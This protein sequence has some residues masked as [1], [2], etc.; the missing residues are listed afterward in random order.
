[1]QNIDWN[2]LTF[3]YTDVRCHIRS[4]WRDGK[5]ST[6]ELVEEP[7]LKMHIAATCLHY[8][9]EAFE[10]LKAFRCKD[11]KVR[12]FR[13]QANGERMFNTARRACMAQVPVDLFEEAVRQAVKANEDFVPPY[14]TGGS[15]YIR[16]LLIGTGPQIGVAP[17]DEYTFLV[18]VMPVGAYYKGG[19]KPVRALIVDD[20]DRAAPQGMGDVKVGGN[21][22]ASLFA[23]ESAKHAGYPVEL[24]L[25]AKTHS[26][27]EEFATSNFIG[28]KKDGTY[29]T[30]DSRSVLPSVTNNTLKQIA[31]DLGMKV[32]VRPVPYDELETFAEIA[33][34]GTAVVVTPVCEIT[35]G[36]KV[37]KTGDPD[38]CGPT[39]Q[40]LYDT[41]QGIQ[42]GLLP[43]THGWCIE[44]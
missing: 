42:Y 3:K 2:S 27:V 24:Y 25:D 29:V 4:V 19:L 43:D 22:A 44:L 40:K 20:W 15:M 18:M 14:G 26:F 7:Y 31:A 5:W 30:P 1:M 34:C 8:G 33:A 9:Q 12:I 32:E 21:Y 11:G 38:G 39:L 17:A 6:L 37:I 13:A 10:G 36:N 35:R 23:H 28:I 16:P 41:V